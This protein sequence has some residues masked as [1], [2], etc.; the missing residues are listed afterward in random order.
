LDRDPIGTEKAKYRWLDDTERKKYIN[1]VERFLEKYGQYTEA[2]PL[3]GKFG[4]KITFAPDERAF[5]RGLNEKDAW[6]EYAAHSLSGKRGVS[7]VRHFDS[8]KV[9]NLNGIEAILRDADGYVN[10]GDQIKYY[11]MVSEE[12]RGHGVIIL[13][14]KKRGDKF[15]ISEDCL[16]Y[17]TH[18]PNKNKKYIEDLIRGAA[19]TI[20]VVEA[21]SQDKPTGTEFPVNEDSLSKGPMEVKDFDVLALLG[22]DR[23]DDE[24]DENVRRGR[25]GYA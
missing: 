6:I 2:N 17:V 3:I 4:H 22:L 20:P 11:K 13:E 16:R 8:S 9:K 14:V 15:E 24:G 12:K 21:P 25:V 23:N 7:H 19:S 1:G 5:G 10:V 18:L